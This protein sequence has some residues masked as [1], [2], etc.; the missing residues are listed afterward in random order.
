MCA[1]I[2]VPIEERKARKGKEVKMEKQLKDDEIGGY[3]DD[4]EMYVEGNECEH[5]IYVEG[6]DDNL[7]RFGLSRIGMRNSLKKGMTYR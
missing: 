7:T 3:D 4:V 2:A 1:L 6:D 5:E